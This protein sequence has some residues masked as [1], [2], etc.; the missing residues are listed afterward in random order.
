MLSPSP[1]SNLSSTSVTFGW[2]AGS[3]TSYRLRLGSSLGGSDI[4][5]S[6]SITRTSTTAT[7]LPNDGTTVYARL[8]SRVGQW[9]SIDYTYKGFLQLA[10]TSVQRLNNGHI[11]LKGS[12]VPYQDYAI[13]WA[14]NL[15]STPRQ[16]TTVHT[17]SSGNFQYEDGQASASSNRYYWVSILNQ[18]Q[19][20]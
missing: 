17:D 10:I 14:P 6:R 8:L 15:S 9:Q 11:V 2:S 20:G 1:G 5:D 19:G 13:M 18:Q 16:L 4:Y 12:G 7:N 3:A